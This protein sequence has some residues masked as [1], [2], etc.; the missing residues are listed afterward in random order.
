MSKL[1]FQVRRA[2]GILLSPNDFSHLRRS[3]Y[4]ALERQVAESDSAAETVATLLRDYLRLLQ[5]PPGSGIYNSV[6]LSEEVVIVA[7]EMRKIG[8][9]QKISVADFL[10]KLDFSPPEELRAVFV[11]YA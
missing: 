8:L 4:A 11:R 7:A 5:S 9:W 10:S 2:G 1:A 6:T 3:D